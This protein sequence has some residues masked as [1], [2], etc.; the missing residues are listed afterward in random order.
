MDTD[1]HFYMHSVSPHTIWLEQYE[2]A[3]V[4]HKNAPFTLVC[5]FGRTVDAT[6][7]EVIWHTAW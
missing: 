2:T 3:V 7:V 4:Y 6:F 1:L 5:V